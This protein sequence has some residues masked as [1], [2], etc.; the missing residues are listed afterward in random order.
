MRRSRWL[1]AVLVVALASSVLVACSGSTHAA[2]RETDAQLATDAYVW[3]YPLVVTER[4][5]QSLARLAPVN[6]LTFQPARSNVST[7]TVV[8]PNTDTLYAVAPLDLR[9]EPYVLTL[10]SITDRYYVFQFISA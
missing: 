7:R 6:R 3:G 9:S 2:R 8:A 5:L 1:P 4:T 10:P